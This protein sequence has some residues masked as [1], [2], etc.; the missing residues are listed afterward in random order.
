MKLILSSIY[1]RQLSVED[2]RPIGLHPAT[3][4]DAPIHFDLHA[5]NEVDCPEYAASLYI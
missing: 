3:E 2:C 5:Y 4:L 1:P